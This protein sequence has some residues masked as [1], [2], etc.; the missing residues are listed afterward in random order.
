MFK[1]KNFNNNGEGEAGVAPVGVPSRSS[2][3][4][5][6]DAI[7]VVGIFCDIYKNYVNL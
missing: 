2:K 1:T 6:S 4:R 7:N 3:A 5:P